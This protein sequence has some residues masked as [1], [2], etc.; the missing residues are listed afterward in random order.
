MCSQGAGHGGPK[1]LN[2]HESLAKCYA[3]FS[4]YKCDCTACTKF[5]KKNQNAKTG[6][7]ARVVK[8]VMKPPV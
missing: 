8:I 7:Y 2:L 4:G 6:L 1:K 3:I 5:T